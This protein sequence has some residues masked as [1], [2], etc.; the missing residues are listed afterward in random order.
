MQTTLT[1]KCDIRDAQAV[2]YEASKIIDKR[3]EYQPAKFKVKCRT[4]SWVG[5][6]SCN[7]R[8]PSC[9]AVIKAS[10]IIGGFDQIP[11]W[12]PTPAAGDFAVAYQSSMDSPEVV[13]PFCDWTGYI[14]ELKIDGNKSKRCPKCHGQIS[15]YDVDVTKKGV[16]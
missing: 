6:C 7:T 1:I 13:C 2:L 9:G 3:N 14:I 4:C 15:D 11:V 12:K 16:V 5:V 8:C 10:D